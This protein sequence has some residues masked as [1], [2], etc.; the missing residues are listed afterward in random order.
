MPDDCSEDC[1]QILIDVRTNPGGYLENVFGV[2]EAIF[3]TDKTNATGFSYQ[4]ATLRMRADTKIPY[5]YV[6]NRA[7]VYDWENWA[8]ENEVPYTSSTARGFFN[9]TQTLKWGRNGVK[10][11]YSK[12]FTDDAPRLRDS[13]GSVKSIVGGKKVALLS[14]GQC[15]SACGSFAFAMRYRLGT[16]L[17]TV[18]GIPGTPLQ[19]CGGAGS[20]VAQDAVGTFLSSAPESALNRPD[21]PGQFASQRITLYLPFTFALQPGVPVPLDF[22]PMTADLGLDYSPQSISDPFSVWVEAAKVFE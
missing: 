9:P 16:K 13:F 14:D 1:T 2:M 20:I 17:V 11:R 6:A 5:L 21:A 15:F 10:G 4:S 22:A 18:G 7:G 3:G 8:D 12:A 19:F